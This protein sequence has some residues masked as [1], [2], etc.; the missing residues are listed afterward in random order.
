MLLILPLFWY[1]F[2]NGMSGALLYESFIYQFFNLFFASI[3]IIIFAVFDQEYE[4]ELLEKRPDLY[5]P[6]I[7]DKYFNLKLFWYWFA[8]ASVQSI[9]IALTAYESLLLLLLT[10]FR[11]GALTVT[12]VNQQGMV[13]DFLDAGMMT[14]SS[15]VI[16]VNLKILLFTNRFNLLVAFWIILSIIVFVLL[17][18]LFNLMPFIELYQKFSP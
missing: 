3:P 17:F 8:S 12:F 5:T 16:C 2:F 13:L 4:D 1:G 7:Y 15:V 10:K 18:Y 9:F 11:F 14:Y 6:G